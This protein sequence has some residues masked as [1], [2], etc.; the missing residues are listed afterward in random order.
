MK[1]ALDAGHGMSTPGKRTPDGE[2]EWSFNNKVLIAC[3]K[4]LESYQGV[5]ILRLDDPT[6]KTDVPLKTRTK[7]ANDWKAD[8]LISIHHNANT[9]KWGSWGGVET[10]VHSL[11]NK[12]AH[13]LAKVVNPAIVSAMGLRNRG[14]KQKNLH[15]TRE[16]HMPAILTEGGFMDS[17]T[18]I[19]ALRNNNKLEAQGIAIAKAVASFYGLK[20][21]SGKPASPSKPSQPNTNK[22]TNS[23]IADEVMLGRWGNGKERVDR[24]TKAGYDY[25]AI[26]SIVDSRNKKPALKP[27]ETVAREVILGKWGNGTTR[28]NNLK[29]AGYNPAEVQKVVNRLI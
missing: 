18:D 28:V 22:K 21:S 19:H 11:N 26:Q 27:I 1:I 6:G 3:K 15:M 7:K 9:S 8:L 10:F 29:K 13:K 25:K 23:Q 12:T 2:R 4:E 5:Q 17:T 14:V 20:K 16:S 24:L